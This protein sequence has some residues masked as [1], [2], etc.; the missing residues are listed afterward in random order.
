MP[1]SNS[2]RWVVIRKGLRKGHSLCR[3][4]CGTEREVSNRN[5][6]QGTSSSCGCLQRK[7]SLAAF[8]ES[9]RLG[10]GR[11]KEYR[12]WFN[13]RAR[14]FNPEH[15]QYGNYGGRGITV[16]DRWQDFANFLADVGPKPSPK[17]TLDRHPDNDGNYEPGNVRW[18]TAKEQNRNQRRT[19]KVTYGSRT[20]CVAAWAELLGRRRNSLYRSMQRLGEQE[21]L[22]AAFAKQ[23]TPDAERP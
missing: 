15:R 19:R 12:A 9:G 18:A 16:C 10:G 5:L 14:C 23:G 2:T 20:M 8:I 4:A 7:V 1:K 6:R 13:M 22:R 3:C 21:A 11:T 17:H